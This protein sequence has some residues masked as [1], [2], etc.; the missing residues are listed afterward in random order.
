MVYILSSGH[1]EVVMS[2]SWQQLRFSTRR[3]IGCFMMGLPSLP[4]NWATVLVVFLVSRWAWGLTV[5]TTFRCTVT[6]PSKV[7]QW[8][9]KVSLSLY[10]LKSSLACL[11]SKKKGAA[12]FVRRRLHLLAMVP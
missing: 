8:F 11:A 9:D 1:V 4:S 10:Y 12:C 6:L 3:E 2:K 5:E 7:W